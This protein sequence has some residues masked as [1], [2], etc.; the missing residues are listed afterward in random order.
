MNYFIWNIYSHFR[1]ISEISN[2]PIGDVNSDGVVNIVDVVQTVSMVLGT[3][4]LNQT[5]DINNDEL[6]NVI[7]IVSLVNI[8]L[9]TN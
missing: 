8:I 4:D 2:S 5:A 3:V 9:G 7:D 1:T 6:I